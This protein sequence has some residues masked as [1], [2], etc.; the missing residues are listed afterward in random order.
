MADWPR[1]ERAPT[2]ES[3]VTR[4]ERALT[5]KSDMTR[6]ERAPTGQL[7]TGRATSAHRL[8]KGRLAAQLARTG[9]DETGRATSADGGKEKER[10]KCR[11]EELPNGCGKG[12]RGQKEGVVSK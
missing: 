12:G 9:R 3:D 10:K 8:D 5:D 1:N 2:D 7:Q 6:N 4:N 11:R